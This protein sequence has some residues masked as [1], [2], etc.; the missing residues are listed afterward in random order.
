M[1]DPSTK[2]SAIDRILYSTDSHFPC[3][4]VFA[5]EDLPKDLV[6]TFLDRLEISQKKSLNKINPLAVF[7]LIKTPSNDIIN[8]MHQAVSFDLI[9]NVNMDKQ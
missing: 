9:S 5:R 1:D 7:G 3:G 8:K 4:I 2:K 6:T